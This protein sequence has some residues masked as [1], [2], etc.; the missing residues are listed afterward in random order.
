MDICSAT[1][2]LAGDLNFTVPKANLTIAEIVVLRRIHGDDAVVDI[3]KTGEAKRSLGRE[4]GRLGTIYG[5]TQA[6]LEMLD[7]VFS[8]S[9][10]QPLLSV[11]DLARAPEPEL[12]DIQAGAAGEDEDEDIVPI[13]PTA[14]EA[15][16][17]ADEP[18]P[19]DDD[20]GKA[21]VPLAV[22]LAASKGTG[23]ATV[24]TTPA[25]PARSFRKN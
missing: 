1:V 5:L 3:V 24:R 25:P 16:A 18:E 14:A 2:R 21:D 8:N 12:A 19:I 13:T 4:R 23:P 20:T 9:A 22:M 6:R 11:D 7:Q 17:Q 15:S 10:V